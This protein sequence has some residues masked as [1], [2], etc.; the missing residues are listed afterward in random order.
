VFGYVCRESGLR[1]G[2]VAMPPSDPV[3]DRAPH[4]REGLAKSYPDRN[5]GNEVGS[6]MKATRK[7]KKRADTLEEGSGQGYLLFCMEEQEGV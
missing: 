4:I 5:R 2:N 7:I 3:D 1:S 6:P